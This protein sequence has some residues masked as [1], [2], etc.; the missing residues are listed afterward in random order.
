MDNTTFVVEDDYYKAVQQWRQAGHVKERESPNAEIFAVAARAAA[1]RGSQYGLWTLDELLYSM[2]ETRSK[3]ERLTR[4]LVP[5]EWCP[6]A[7]EEAHLTFFSYQQG[8]AHCWNGRHVRF[9][10]RVARVH[11]EKESKVESADLYTK[12]RQLVPVDTAPQILTHRMPDV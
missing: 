7:N 2:P 12:L 10:K 4:T 3:K 6:N 1:S 8:D 5:A 9:R 11:K